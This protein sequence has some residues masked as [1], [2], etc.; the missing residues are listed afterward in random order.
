MCL[1]LLFLVGCSL[2]HPLEGRWKTT[3]ADGT[4]SQLTF[5]SDGTFN[6]LSKGEKL[7]G[8]WKYHEEP[9]PNQLELIFE[10]NRVLTIAKLIG[11]QLIIEPREQDAAMPA[12][13]T[14]AAQKYRRQ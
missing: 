8:K 5:R 6:A 14:D 2:T 11:D 12:D 1:L 7:S 4:E 3:S 13:F 9:E 10:D